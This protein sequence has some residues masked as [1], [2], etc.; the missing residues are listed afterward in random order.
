MSLGTLYIRGA[1]RRVAPLAV[2]KEL[3]LDVKVVDIADAPE[4][5]AKYFPLKKIPGFVSSKGLVIHEV[6]AIT[7]YL[8]NQVPGTKLLGS[9][10]D[11]YA[12]VLQWFSFA[13]TDLWNSLRAIIFPLI[14]R[15][16]YNKKG[17]ETATEDAKKFID[18]LE[19]S[20]S[21]RTY[22]VG[23][24]LT[25]ADYHLAAV[26][27]RAFSNIWDKPFI[28]QHP[29]IYRWFN[30]VVSQ[31]PLNT[32]YT[33]PYPYR[34]E[35]VKYTPPKKEAKPKAEPKPKP[36]AEPKPKE[37]PI[38]E[39]PKEKKVAHPLAALGLPK[40]SLDE[41]KR[42]YSNEETREVAL[43]WFWQHH[44]PE[45][46]SLWKV[47]YK[48]NDELTLTFMSNNLVGGF[49]NRLTASTKYLFGCMVVYGENNNN[50]IIGVFLVR[51]QDYA[52]A[53]DVAPDWDSYEYTKLDPSKP[54]DKEFIEDLWAWDKPVVIDGKKY[55]IADGKVLK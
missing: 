31:F 33:V 32:I 8:V 51:G 48:Y 38:D 52:P 21:T 25:V 2:I 36:K 46:Y 50:G 55:E 12:S 40:L 37:E 15:L 9:N 29:N 53:F 44:D 34:D 27:E 24:R 47:A 39:P 23:E 35:A 7:I 6:M 14:G 10:N 30:T 22:L 5:F 17:V 13:N 42:T 49:F 4:E 18:Y 26:T 54:E 16:P 41:W 1:L 45:E 28:A 3:N 20:L 19:N 11:E 43:P